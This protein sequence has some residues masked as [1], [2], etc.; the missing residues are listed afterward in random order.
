MSDD[1]KCR[2]ADEKWFTNG[3]RGK[4]TQL[5]LQVIYQMK[6]NGGWKGE[7]IESVLFA[8][9]FLDF[10][11]IVALDYLSLVQFLFVPNAPTLQKIK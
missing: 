4:G 1:I 11:E 6:S 9:Q 10:V 7:G 3:T 2:S 8:V 5:N